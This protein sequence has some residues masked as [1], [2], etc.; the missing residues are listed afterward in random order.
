M[1]RKKP[2]PGTVLVVKGIHDAQNNRYNYETVEVSEVTANEQLE[3]EIKSRNHH[4]KNVRYAD[5]DEFE[6]YYGVSREEAQAEYDA[7][8]AVLTEGG[9]QE[10]VKRGRKPREVKEE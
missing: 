5:D 4:W 8:V 10:K 1:K 7:E 2:T 9:L 6:K 3:K